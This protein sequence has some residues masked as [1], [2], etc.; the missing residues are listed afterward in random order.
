MGRGHLGKQV[1]ARLQRRETLA[2]GELDRFAKSLETFHADAGRYPTAKEG[3][4]ALIKQPSTVAAW[5]GPY[6]EGDYSLD[7]WGNEYVYHAFDD[8]AAYE[9]FTYGP[10]GEAAARPF[11]QINSGN[12]KP[13]ASAPSRLP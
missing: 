1:Q 9:L 10:D 12:L 6:V 3:L 2:R 13:P 5:R 7:P 4:N 11:L 8:G